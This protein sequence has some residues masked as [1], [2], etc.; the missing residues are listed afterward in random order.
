MFLSW[1]PHIIRYVPPL[2]CKNLCCASHFARVAGELGQ[3]IQNF[4][5]RGHEANASWGGGHNLG[6]LDEPRTRKPGD[7][8]QAEPTT[9]AG[10]SLN[11]KEQKGGGEKGSQDQNCTN[12]SEGRRSFTFTTKNRQKNCKNDRALLPLGTITL[13]NS[14]DTDLGKVFFVKQS[15]LSQAEYSKTLNSSEI[16]ERGNRALVIVF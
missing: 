13:P 5:Q 7:T 9:Q 10:C 14:F 2:C 4:A 8:T 15:S 11:I 16:R 6:L 3:Q 1:T 12:L